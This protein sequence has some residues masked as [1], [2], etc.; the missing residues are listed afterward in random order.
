MRNLENIRFVLLNDL[1]GGYVFFILSNEHGQNKL[2]N[3][4]V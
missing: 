1:L 2:K 4:I 3:T